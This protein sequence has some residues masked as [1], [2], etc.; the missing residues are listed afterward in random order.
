MRLGRCRDCTRG[1][2][3]SF[4]A[5]RLRSL[6]DFPFLSDRKLRHF[7]R[8]QQRELAGHEDDGFRLERQ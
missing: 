1:F 7:D 4:V 8:K 6:D 3:G 2:F 5:V